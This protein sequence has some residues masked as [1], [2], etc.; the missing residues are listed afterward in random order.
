[1]TSTLTDPG[2]VDKLRQLKRLQAAAS[3]QA[4]RAWRKIAHHYQLPPPGRWF[5]WLLLGGRGAGK[6]FTGAHWILEKVHTTPGTLWGAIGPTWRDTLDVPIRGILEVLGELGYVEGVDYEYHRSEMHFYFPNG[7]EIKG[8]SAD[9]PDRIRGANLAGAWVDELAAYPRPEVFWD[10]ALVFA[11]RIGEQPQILVTTTP[12]SIRLIVELSKRDDGSVVK[13]R[14][15]TYENKAN[16]SPVSLA[17]YERRYEGTRLGRQELHGE[18]LTDTPGALWSLRRIDQ[19][20][21]VT[22]P[23][24]VRVHIGVDPAVS[25]GQ[26][27]DETGI[28]VAGKTHRLCPVCG[29]SKDSGHYIVLEDVSGRFDPAGWARQVT[30]AYTRH[31]GDRV[32]AEKNNGGLLVKQSLQQFD[33]TL[34]VQLVWASRGKH[35]R[36]EPVAIAYHE[37][38]V[39]HLGVL[40]DLE[41][42]MTSWVPGTGWSPDRLDALVWAL[43]SLM[44]NSAPRIVVRS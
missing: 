14:G 25:V 11:V 37:G 42:Q 3:T 39:H 41:D 16:L 2:T 15:S 36:A 30:E 43:T 34:P 10:E 6:T 1:M 35:T 27:S 20:R 33:R 28:V 24:L 12:R 44:S 8:Y 17:E 32:V 19:L 38:R 22:L 26:D 5:V 18:V 23:D 29:D 7:S 4:V 31:S 9:K 40:K 21:A 13:T